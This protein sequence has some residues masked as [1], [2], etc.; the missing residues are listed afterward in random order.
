MPGLDD[1]YKILIE[2]PRRDYSDLIHKVDQE[3]RRVVERSGDFRP[4]KP[5]ASREQFAHW[6]G[7]RNFD[8]DKDIV[9]V[10][11][12]PD[13]APPDEVR[14]LEVNDLAALPE[15]APVEAVDFMPDIDG[16]DFKLYVADV[17]PDQFKKITE[18]SLELPRG[19]S[20]TDYQEV[21]PAAR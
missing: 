10:L 9:R 20:L 12:L 15:N 13:S 11:F 7:R 8:I 2:L 4:P 16:L 14:L 1:V 21:A 3:R 6:I 19:W 18:R 17:T 5:G